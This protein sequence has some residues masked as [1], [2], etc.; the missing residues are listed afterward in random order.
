MISKVG[1]Y[2]G[3]GQ[4]PVRRGD[5]PGS[6]DAG[7]EA[8]LAQGPEPRS[9]GVTV[10]GDQQVPGEQDLAAT[11]QLHPGLRDGNPRSQLSRRPESGSDGEHLLRPDGR[12]SGDGRRVG[13]RVVTTDGDHLSPGYP[14][15]G[16]RGQRRGIGVTGVHEKGQ[17]VQGRRGLRA[18]SM[19]GLVTT[20]MPGS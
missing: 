20:R 2:P 14:R 8:L 18:G 17:V 16:D 1:Y 19:A 6:R 7:R 9:A 4:G 12:E 5:L 3:A 15:R 13:A 11:G 10:E